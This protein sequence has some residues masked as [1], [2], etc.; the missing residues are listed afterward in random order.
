MTVGPEQHQKLK[1]GCEQL[2]LE[3]SDAQIEAC[4]LHLTEMHRWNRTHNLTSIKKLDDMLILHT[5]DALSIAH[6]I[7]GNQVMDLGTGPGVP[8]IPLAIVFPEKQF[9]LLDASQKKT[10][11]LRSVITR[12]KLKNCEVRTGRVENLD[13]ISKFDVIVSRAVADP[14]ILMNL[15]SD[16][17]RSGGDLVCMLGNSVDKSAFNNQF[18]ACE[19]IYGLNV[20][21]LDAKRQVALVKRR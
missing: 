9:T 4:L 19:S 2:G 7:L 21:F 12:L 14:A 15:T 16:V 18:F 8:G 6:Y 1:D 5:L 10:S 3:L 13:T 11:F 20:P 17:L